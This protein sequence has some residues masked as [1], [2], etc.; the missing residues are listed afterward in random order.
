MSEEENENEIETGSEE[1]LRKIFNFYS[2]H[3]N[4]VKLARFHPAENL[5]L[6]NGTHFDLNRILNPYPGTSQ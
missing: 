1:E 4:I 2:F 5:T 3:N 6:K